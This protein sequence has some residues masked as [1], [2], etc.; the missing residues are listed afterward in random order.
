MFYL[1][2]LSTSTESHNNTDKLINQ[3]SGIPV[4]PVSMESGNDI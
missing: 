1:I 3:G 2:L 4:A